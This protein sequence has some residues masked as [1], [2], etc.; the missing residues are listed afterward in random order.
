MITFAADSSQ[1]EFIIGTEIGI[2]YPLSKANPDK[3]FIPASPDM[4][5][6]D[7]KKIGLPEILKSLEDLAPE[8]KVP[9]KTRRKARRAVERML[10]LSDSVSRPEKEM[11]VNTKDKII[12]ETMARA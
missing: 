6:P 10:A 4:L 1:K 5:C 2:L 9:D 3:V 7:M 12:A 8:V 11:R